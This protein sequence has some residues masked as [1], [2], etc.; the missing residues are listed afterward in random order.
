VPAASSEQAPPDQ[1]ERAPRTPLPDELSQQIL[2][3]TL[4]S[5]DAPRP[6]PGQAAKR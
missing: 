6:A 1:K 3:D 2:L 5:A 4:D